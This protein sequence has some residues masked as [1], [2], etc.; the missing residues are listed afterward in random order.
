MWLHVAAYLAMLFAYPRVKGA[1]DWPRA[2]RAAAARLAEP[3]A[4][5]TAGFNP[6]PPEEEYAEPPRQDAG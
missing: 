3:A 6:A 5:A 4:D 1:I 2:A